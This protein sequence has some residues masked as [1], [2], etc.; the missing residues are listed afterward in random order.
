MNNV[1][2]GF[3]GHSDKDFSWGIWVKH[4]LPLG[5]GGCKHGALPGFT[6]R[7]IWKGESRDPCHDQSTKQHKGVSP[8][9]GGIWV[10][11]MSELLLSRMD[12]AVLAALLEVTSPKRRSLFIF[13]APF[14]F[15]W[16]G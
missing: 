9:T 11:R 5:S 3:H 10:Q 14:P 15:V 16:G 2:T 1:A 12:K 8:A 13:F 6:W 4:E 7:A